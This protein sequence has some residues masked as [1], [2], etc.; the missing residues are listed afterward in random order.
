P[1][2]F[3]R[4][5]EMAEMDTGNLPDIHRLLEEELI[6]KQRLKDNITK[7][8]ARRS[9]VSLK[10]VIGKFG[11]PGGLA[12]ALTYVSMAA[13]WGNKCMING[14]EYEPVP[15]DAAAGKYLRT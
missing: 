5:P 2:D 3:E 8:L 10:E 11:C 6:D 4:L 15:F 7:M 14:E 9:Q 13:A 1:A 12:E